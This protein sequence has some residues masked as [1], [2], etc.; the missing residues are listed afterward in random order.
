MVAFYEKKGEN[1]KN[2]CG[3]LPK[4]KLPFSP[5]APV[6]TGSLRLPYPCA[7]WKC[8]GLTK[9]LQLELFPIVVN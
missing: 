7:V 2:V 5:S 8:A 9:T 4:G 6:L 1:W 3:S